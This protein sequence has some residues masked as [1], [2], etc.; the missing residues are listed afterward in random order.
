MNVFL[1][2]SSC[3]FSVSHSFFV[4]L[5]SYH[6]ITVVCS[7]DS[8]YYER[9]RTSKKKKNDAFNKSYFFFSLLANTHWIEIELTIYNRSYLL[10]SYESSV[11]D[12][13]SFFSLLVST[14]NVNHGRRTSTKRTEDCTGKFDFIFRK[15]SM[16]S[17]RLLFRLKTKCRHRKYPEEGEEEKKTAKCVFI[18]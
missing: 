11:L 8:S 16:Q 7:R 5:L 17:I 9:K 2:V 1:Y 10:L 18:T 4:L 15:K 3:F 14:K 13:Q 6:Y 12:S